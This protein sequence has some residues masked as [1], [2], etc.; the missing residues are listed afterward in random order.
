MTTILDN[1]QMQT[2]NCKLNSRKSHR[3]RFLG[4]IWPHAPA[5]C[6][7]KKTVMEC[8]GK[9]TVVTVKEIGASITLKKRIIERIHCTEDWNFTET[10]HEVQF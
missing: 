4:G 5:N 7:E 8:N 3:K 2:N 9:T 6:K 10:H 1:I